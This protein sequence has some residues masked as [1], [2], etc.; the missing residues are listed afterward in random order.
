MIRSISFVFDTFVLL[1]NLLYLG[2]R[3]LTSAEEGLKVAVAEVRGRHRGLT[4]RQEVGKRQQQ[5]RSMPG[6]EEVWQEFRDW[7]LTIPEES[8]GQ[9][10]GRNPAVVQIDPELYRRMIE[11]HLIPEVASY[12]N[13]TPTTFTVCLTCSEGNFNCEKD[14]Q[15]KLSVHSLFIQE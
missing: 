12:I 4:H 9:L 3:S 1:L 7:A 5:V 8:W 13:T 2:T 15:G 10:T 6:R 11:Y 14:A